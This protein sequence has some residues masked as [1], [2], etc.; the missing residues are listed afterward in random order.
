MRVV[1]E[2]DREVARKEEIKP[3]GKHNPLMSKDFGDRAKPLTKKSAKDLL[4]Q[5]KE[6]GYKILS[7]KQRGELEERV[8]ESKGRRGRT[9]EVDP[10]N[11]IKGESVED[12]AKRIMA[13]YG[14]K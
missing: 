14:S 5:D 10:L 7:S 11:R 4:Q 13:Q 6:K 1:Y 8:G 12:Y 9:K 3:S 2:P